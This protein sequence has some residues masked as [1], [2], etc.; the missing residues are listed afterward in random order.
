[1]ALVLDPVTGALVDENTLKKK[2]ELAQAKKKLKA[3][4][5]EEPDDEDVPHEGG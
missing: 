4:K 3:G 2:K 1:M 5:Q